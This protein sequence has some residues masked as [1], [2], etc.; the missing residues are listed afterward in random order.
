MILFI[1]LIRE[2]KYCSGGYVDLL[3]A[4][5]IKISMTTKTSPYD[6]ALIEA[7]FR[8]LKAEEVYL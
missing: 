2:L 1:T 6:N 8:T 7:F 5:G 3:K 4:H